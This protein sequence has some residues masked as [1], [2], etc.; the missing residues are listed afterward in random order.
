[1]IVQ[2][3]PRLTGFALTAAE[4]RLFAVTWAAGFLFVSILIA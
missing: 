3:A 2:T 1:M 4:L